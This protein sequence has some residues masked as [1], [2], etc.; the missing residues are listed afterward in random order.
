[1]QPADKE[2]PLRH[3]NWLV[4]ILGALAVSAVI[5]FISSP[6]TRLEHLE[7]RVQAIEVARAGSDAQMAALRET[8]TELKQQQALLVSKIDDIKSELMASRRPQDK[9]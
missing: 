4:P 1:M 7:A 6:V 9:R 5:S 2:N 3:F 8:L